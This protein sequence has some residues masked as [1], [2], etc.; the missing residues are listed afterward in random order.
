MRVTVVI[1][2]T[3]TQMVRERDGSDFGARLPLFTCSIGRERTGTFFFDARRYNKLRNSDCIVTLYWFRLLVW[4]R[5]Y[6][7][8]ECCLQPEEMGGEFKHP[9]GDG[10]IFIYRIFVN[11]ATDVYYVYLYK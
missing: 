5:S 10:N 2:E 1:N 11:K 4:N 3:A 7:A 8:N 9:G 6:F